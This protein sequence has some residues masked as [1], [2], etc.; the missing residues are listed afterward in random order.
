[1]GKEKHNPVK[2]DTKI[3]LFTTL[4]YLNYSFKYLF[5]SS[6]LFQSQSIFF[7]HFVSLI[8]LQDITDKTWAINKAKHQGVVDRPFNSKV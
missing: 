7:F 3:S 2:E 6:L 1:M 4:E 8:C 5:L